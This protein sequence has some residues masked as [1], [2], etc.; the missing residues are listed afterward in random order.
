MSDDIFSIPYRLQTP[1]DIQRAKECNFLNL[2]KHYKTMSK[3]AKTTVLAK[4]EALKLARQSA[5]ATF[6]LFRPEKK[7][8][9]RDVSFEELVCSWSKNHFEEICKIVPSAKLGAGQE[10][11][12]L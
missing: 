7:K 8:I 10:N 2:G 4:P 6:T 9:I 12:S 1:E 11:K 5:E 3:L